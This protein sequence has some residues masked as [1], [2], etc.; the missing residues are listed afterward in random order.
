VSFALLKI[1]RILIA[2]PEDVEPIK[3]SKEGHVKRF[4]CNEAQRLTSLILSRIFCRLQAQINSRR[5]RHLCREEA[6]LG[7]SSIKPMD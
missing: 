6:G 5:H 2:Q 7:L 3:V 1:E 4:S